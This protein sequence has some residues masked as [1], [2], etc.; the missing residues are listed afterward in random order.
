MKFKNTKLYGGRLNE[1][2]EPKTN[3][4]IKIIIFLFKFFY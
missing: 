2:I 1:L 4:I 3:G